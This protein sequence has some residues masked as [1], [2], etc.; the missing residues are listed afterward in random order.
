MIQFLPVA[1]SESSSPLNPLKKLHQ[2]PSHKKQHSSYSR[3]DSVG[4]FKNE[5]HYRTGE[6]VVV[7]FATDEPKH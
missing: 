6:R 1:N 2:K 7:H 4:E 5:P 3:T